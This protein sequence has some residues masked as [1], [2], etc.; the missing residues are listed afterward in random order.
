MIKSCTLLTLLL[1]IFS[2]LPA[3]KRHKDSVSLTIHLNNKANDQAQVDSVY[4]IF[5]RYDLSGAGLVKKVFLP[6]DNTI[7]IEKLPKGKYYVEVYCLG[8][9]PGHFN[10]LIMA[11]PKARSRHSFRL[12]KQEFY[13]VGMAYIPPQKVDFSHL[14]VTKSK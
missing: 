6:V 11:H 14:S 3:Q 7:R 1:V 4:L 8:N 12:R 13:P 10:K 5:D 9:Y 2:N